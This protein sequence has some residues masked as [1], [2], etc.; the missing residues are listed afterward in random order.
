MVAG[1]RLSPLTVHFC[2][3]HRRGVGGQLVCDMHR[4]VVLALRVHDLYIAQRTRVADLAAHLG[5]ERRL[6][7]HYLIK[8]LAFLTHLTVAQNL[9]L[10]LQLV[11]AHELRLAFTEHR[12]VAQILFVGA[13]SHLFLM[14]ERAVVFLFVRGKSVL[15]QNQLRQ[16]E[17]EAVSVFQREH[18]RARNLL[19]FGFFHQ[20]VQQRDALLQ[21]AEESL[22]LALDNGDNLLLLRPQFG[23]RIAHI[24]NQLRHQLV[25]ERVTLA[26]ERVGI[27]HRTAQDSADDIARLLIARQLP[28]RDGKRDSTDVVGYHAHRNVGLLVLAIDASADF[29]YAAEHRL[30]H[31]GVVVRLLALQ[32]AHQAFETHAGVNHLVGQ[33]FQR[34]VRLAVVL[35]EHKVPYL[36][37]LRVVFVHQLAPGHRFLLLLVAAVHVY[38]RARS[39]GPR[40]AHFP[41]V[42]MLVAVQ[43][44][45]SGQVL[46]P[47]RRRLAVALKAL[48]RRTLKDSHIQVFRVDMKHIHD[49]FPR[50]VDCPF[51]EVVAER[52]VAQHL[53]HRM[54]VRVVPHLFQVVVLAAHAQTFLRVRHSR[55]LYRVVA[56]DNA[57]PWVHA[58]I[59]EHQSRVVFDNHRCRG[60]HVMPLRSHEIQKGLTYFFTCHTLFDYLIIYNLTIR[61]CL[62]LSPLSLLRRQ[63]S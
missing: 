45:V 60:H 21:R 18:V 42:V 19:A 48:F 3:Q 27:A 55:E 50:E 62:L 35:H 49:V 57:F 25:E 59:G 40:V 63:W 30:E 5:V 54:V 39:A 12:P 10:D 47:Y 28:V 8:S 20:F 14:L 2:R 17:R 7:Q 32:R 23:I 31:V 29:A 13:A 46:F 43:D 1:Y 16:V 51:F 56:E 52:P 33:P 15:A 26:E 36:N 37:H 24:F 22:L 4:E 58:R 9:G 34:A 44:M 61:Y 41:E 11:V 38:L 53:K 6:A